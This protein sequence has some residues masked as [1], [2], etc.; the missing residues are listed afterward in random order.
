M[1]FA[2]SVLAVALICPL[3]LVF[4]VC[5]GRNPLD[6]TRKL[7]DDTVS[8]K[9]GVISQANS[10]PCPNAS[11]Q[12]EIDRCALE[13][14]RKADKEL[15]SVYRRIISKLGAVDRANLIDAQRAW[16]KYR[17]RNCKAE[18]Q[19]HGGTLAPTVEAFCLQDSTQARTKELIRIYEPVEGG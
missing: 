6:A 18:R 2:I 19:F 17:D 12:Q 4:E 9:A 13:H 7:L 1:S 10:D 3:F 14:F 16:L 11:T 8:V 5:E 15:N